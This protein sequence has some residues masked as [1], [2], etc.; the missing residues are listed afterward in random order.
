MWTKTKSLFLS[1][2]LTTIA[3][4]IIILMTIFVPSISELYSQYSA[5]DNITPLRATSSVLGDY[6]IPLS[7]ISLK[8]IA[9]PTCVMLYICEAFALIALSALQ[10]LLKN[11]SKNNVFTPKNTLCIRIISWACIGVGSVFLVFSALRLIFLAPSFLAFMFGLIMRVLKNVF[12]KAV[13]IKSENDF[14][15]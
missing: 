4:I 3:M 5:I 6:S 12:E 2:V 7:L 10:I 15:I 13:E 9:F 1:R 11:I 8:E 14:T